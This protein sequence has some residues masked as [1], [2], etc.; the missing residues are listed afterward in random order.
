MAITMVQCSRSIIPSMVVRSPKVGAT[1]ALAKHWRARAA[2]G[3]DMNLKQ[4]LVASDGQAEV[5]FAPLQ[6][7]QELRGSLTGRS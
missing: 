7:Q 6:T 4:L 2:T 1:M 5:I 3:F